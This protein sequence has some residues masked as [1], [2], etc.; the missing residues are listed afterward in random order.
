MGPDSGRN[1]RYSAR[2]TSWALYLSQY[3]F[4]QQQ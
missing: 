1:G 3:S 2:I 4:I